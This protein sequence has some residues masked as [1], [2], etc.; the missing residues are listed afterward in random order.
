MLIQLLVGITDEQKEALIYETSDIAV[1][2]L[3]CDLDKVRVLIQ[4]LPVENWR[5]ASESVK[6]KLK[7]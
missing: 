7:N 6:K 4:D 1:K 2:I 5:I 3:N